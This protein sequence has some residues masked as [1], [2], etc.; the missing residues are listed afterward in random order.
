[1]QLPTYSALAAIAVLSGLLGPAAHAASARPPAA[2]ANRQTTIAPVL[3]RSVNI[4]GV[5]IFYREAG[6]K[7]APVL[8]LLHGFPSS[9]HMYRNLI[10]QLADRYRVIA[11]DYPGFGQS[12]MP[13]KEKFTYSFDHL[14]SVLDK[15]TV[16]VGAG[17][18]A[19]YVQDYGAPVGFR[20]AAAHPDRITALIIQ[21]GNAY[22]EGI[23]NPFWDGLKAYWADRTGA[24]AS[25]LR[26]LLEPGVTKWFYTDGARNAEALSPDAWTSDQAGLDRPGNK[27]IQ[28]ELLY[29]YRSNPSKYAEWQAYFRKFQPPTL[30]VWGKNDKGFPPV[31]AQSYLRDLPRAE[32]H[33]FDTGHFALEEDSAAIGALMR[34]FLGR[35]VTK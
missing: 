4:D 31:A 5:E 12:G 28:L 11:P 27:D 3:Y 23:D 14:A 19:M 32:L 15:F 35:T 33:L 16:A 2:S 21:N 24:R 10:P 29:D 30:I 22:H 18:Y 20:L 25:E 7:N 17:R 9:S 26:K 34:G 1:M 13:P 6:P 8:L